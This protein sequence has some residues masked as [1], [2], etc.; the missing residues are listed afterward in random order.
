MPAHIASYKTFL[1]SRRD[2]FALWFSFYLSALILAVRAVGKM[3]KRQETNG[4]RGALPKINKETQTGFSFRWN[5]SIEYKTVWKVAP[6]AFSV[7]KINPTQH[8]VS[9][10]YF[11]KC[12]LKVTKSTA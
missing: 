11:R 12:S 3:K 4:R 2:L 9:E 1:K 5:A 8:A 6:F 7:S 10:N